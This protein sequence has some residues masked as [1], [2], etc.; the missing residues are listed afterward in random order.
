MSLIEVSAVVANCVHPDSACFASPE[1]AFPFRCVV[2]C[3]TYT[4]DLGTDAS[5]TAI[6]DTWMVLEITAQL[7]SKLNTGPPGL[8]SSLLKAFFIPAASQYSDDDG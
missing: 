7:L 8:D 1:Q 3:T 4:R 2:D 6:W 5:T